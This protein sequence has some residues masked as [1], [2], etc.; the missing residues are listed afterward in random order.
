MPIQRRAFETKRRILVSAVSLFSRYGLNGVSVD[1]IA[2]A[3]QVN[4]QRIYAYYGSKTVLF[5]QCLVQIF[6]E[7]NSLEDNFHDITRDNLGE[8][9]DILLSHYINIHRQVPAFWRLIA[10]ANLESSSSLEK[11][12]GIKNKSLS[13]LNDL[14]QEG[15]RRGILRSEVSFDTYIFNIFAVSF[16]YQANRVTLS[17]TL[18]RGLFEQEGLSKLIHE[19]AGLFKK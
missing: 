13:Y 11:L 4:K 9:T 19:T 15:C 18:S 16:F 7:V 1:K 17:N 5:E 14:Y 8:M 6:E 2:A 3:A 10:W 12:S